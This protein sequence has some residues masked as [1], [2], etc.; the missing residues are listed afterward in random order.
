MISKRCREHLASV[1]LGPIAHARRALYVGAQLQLCVLGLIVHAVAPCLFT[2]H[3]SDTMKDIL[4]ETHNE[5][6]D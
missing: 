4:E 3:A 2:T 5:R 6:S 1:N